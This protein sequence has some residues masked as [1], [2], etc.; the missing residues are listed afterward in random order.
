MHS[1]QA[2]IFI[3]FWMKVMKTHYPGASEEELL[4]VFKKSIEQKEEQIK[5]RR[6]KPMV[7]EEDDDSTTGEPMR[8]ESVDTPPADTPPLAK[9]TLFSFASHTQLPLTTCASVLISASQD[10]VRAAPAESIPI[11]QAFSGTSPTNVCST[12]PTE[13]YL[14]FEQAPSLGFPSINHDTNHF[15]NHEADHTFVHEANH[16]LDHEDHSFDHEANHSVDHEP[17][18]SF[19]HEANQS[20]DHEADHSLDQNMAED[21]DYWWI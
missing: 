21:G 17:S 18:H 6:G 8:D 3:E 7:D 5:L 4:D 15:L 20:L 10:S 19:N 12:Q 13:L 2:S 9:K 11:P 1:I 14:K 16:T